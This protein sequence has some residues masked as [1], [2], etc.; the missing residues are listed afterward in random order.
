MIVLEFILEVI[1]RVFL[2]IIFEGIIC[3]FF[4]LIKRLFGMNK[5]PET[6][7][8]RGHKRNERMKKQEHKSK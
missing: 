6:K 7:A 3:G 2:E 4:G 1:L 8:L 5:S